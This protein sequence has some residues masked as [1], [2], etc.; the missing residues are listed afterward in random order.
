MDVKKY[1]KITIRVKNKTPIKD[2]MKFKRRDQDG[3]FKSLFAAYFVLLL[4]VFL[5]AGTGIT[6]VLF[7]GVYHYLPWIMAGLAILI[8]ALFW[9]FYVRMKKNTREIKD[10]LSFPQFQG[11][12]V[13]IRLLGGVASVKIDGGKST[14]SGMAAIGHTPEANGT[15]V[16]MLG[17]GSEATDKRLADLARLYQDGLISREEFDLA[18]EQIFSE[19]HDNTIHFNQNAGGM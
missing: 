9:I 10:I 7:K 8:I 16:P 18:K 13:E 17:M 19:S 11:R 14:A 6:V 3:V 2:I 12:S 15:G 1:S 4:H 5:L